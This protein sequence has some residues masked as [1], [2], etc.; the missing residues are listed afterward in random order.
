MFAEL[1]AG[2]VDT[3][4][5]AREL[6]ARTEPGLEAII[7][8]FGTAVLLETGEL[9]RAALRRIVFSDPERRRALEAI[10]HP[11]I[12]ART[13]QQLE[14]LDAPYTI[15]VVPLLLETGFDTLVE[16]IVVVDCPEE[17]QLERLCRRDGVSQQDARAMLQAQTDRQTRLAR[18]DDVV[19]NSGS[20]ASTRAQV[21]TLHAR[22]LEI[23]AKARLPK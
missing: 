4:V 9:D 21:E 16:R 14:A 17:Q 2:I 8:E 3:D 20:L 10:L 22:Y 5:I 1:G 18:A 12:R 23:A 7:A 11:L 19:D 6:V 15:V 13:R